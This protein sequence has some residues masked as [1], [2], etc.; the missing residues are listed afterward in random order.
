MLWL[1]LRRRFRAGLLPALILRGALCAALLACIPPRTCAGPPYNVDDP[2]TTAYRHV[3][4]YITYLAG[5]S[6][7]VTT[8]TFPNL[9]VAYGLRP[10]VEI[11]LGASGYTSNVPLPAPLPWVTNPALAAKWRFQEEKDRVPQV[12]AGYQVTF[13]TQ[14]SGLGTGFATHALWLTTGKTVGRWALWANAGLDLYKH[15][16]RDESVFYGLAGDYPVNSR[17]RLGMQLYGNTAATGA[18]VAKDLAWGVG[19]T[20]GL[21]PKTTLLLQG[22]ASLMGSSDLNLYAGVLIEFGR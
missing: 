11:S 2:G 18:G 1:S 15:P 5:T 13:V 22:G 10:N 14:D 9:A 8:A 6:G 7:G 16:D 20:Y 17:L 4:V 3:G 19:A 21:T 12:T